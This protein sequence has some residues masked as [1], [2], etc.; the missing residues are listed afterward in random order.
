MSFPSVFSH[1]PSRCPRAQHRSIYSRSIHLRRPIRLHTPLEDVSVYRGPTQPDV[2]SG[3]D[4]HLVPRLTSPV[5]AV[6][7]SLAR[8]LHVAKVV[9]GDVRE[10]REE[11]KTRWLAGAKNRA[12]LYNGP[13]PPWCEAV[14]VVGTTLLRDFS[15][16]VRRLDS[17][18]LKR[19]LSLLRTRAAMAQ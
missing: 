18:L 10:K 6:G 3:G 5:V 14:A 1:R 9:G 11:R 7:S 13:T 15:A 2:E 8:R 17:R 12:G 19:S 16:L 4:G